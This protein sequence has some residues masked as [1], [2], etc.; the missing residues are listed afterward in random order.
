M[1][2][3]PSPTE[4]ANEHPNT[5]TMMHEWNKLHL[6]KN[7]LLYRHN[8]TYNQLVLPVKFHKLL[9]HQ[10]HEEMRQSESERVVNLARQHFY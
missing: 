7:G 6:E 2:R 1:N 5:K 4:G 8:D 3:K 9:Y 10:L